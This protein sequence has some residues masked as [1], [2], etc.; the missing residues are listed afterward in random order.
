[1]TLPDTVAVVTGA[2][3]GIGRATAAALVAAGATVHG[4]AR[5]EGPLGETARALGE[6]FVPVVCD[7]TDAAA[8]QAA[9]DATA[10]R[11]GRLDILVNNAGVGRFGPV[12][13][14]TDD[15]WDLLVSTNLSGVFYATRAAVR[16]MKAAG[17]G[18]VVNVASVAGLVGNAGLSVYNATKFGL[19]GFS[20]ATMKEL[21]PSGIRV[22][23][24]YPGSVA[25]GFGDAPARATAIP[26]EAVAATIRHCIE[27]P[28]STLI[29]EVV[30]RPMN[31]G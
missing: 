16:H 10:E 13:E 11:H 17:R 2:S 8:V 22:T 31:V 29:S 21:R 26:P 9:V 19:R 3:D 4:F 5:S 24:V 1:M 25:T 6:R 18:H 15:D 7:V 20:D 12:D 14:V 30:M 28:D 27:A 23:C